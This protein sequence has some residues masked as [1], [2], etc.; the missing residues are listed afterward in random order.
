MAKKPSKNG[1]MAIKKLNFSR[2]F[3]HNSDIYK[4]FA[5][6]LDSS[7]VIKGDL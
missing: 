7:S 5:K 6:Y 1:K 4:Y 2:F 3:G